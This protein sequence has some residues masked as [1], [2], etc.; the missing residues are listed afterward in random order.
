MIR[1]NLAPPSAKK[2]IG[3]SIPTFNMGML[4]GAIGPTA[5]VYP[6]VSVAS[7]LLGAG[8]LAIWILTYS[9]ILRGGRLLTRAVAPVAGA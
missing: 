2:G 6:P 1:I 8:S 3:F 5:T 4:F 9:L 7:A